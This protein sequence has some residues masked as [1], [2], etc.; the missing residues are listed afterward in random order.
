MAEKML[1]I[2][3]EEIVLKSC[4]KIFESEGYDVTAT[5]NPQE[6]IRLVSEKS[7]DVI[8]VDWMMP[9]LDGLDVVEE[10]DK[11]SPN[12]AMVMISGHPSLGRA[13]EAMKRGAMDYLPKPFKPGSVAS[14]AFM[15]KL[16]R[17]LSI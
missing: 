8:L 3:D 12:S 10:I 1:I 17:T 16:I 9:G 15:I 11:R 6:G 2:D 13:T 5:P 7:F 4:R 14:S